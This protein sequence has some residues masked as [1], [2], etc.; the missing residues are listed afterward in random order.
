MEPGRRGGRGPPAPRVGLGYGG[1][2]GSRSPARSRALAGKAPLVRGLDT[3]SISGP[4]GSGTGPRGDRES[5]RARSRWSP[6]TKLSPSAVQGLG[7]LVVISVAA[8][9]NNGQASGLFWLRSEGS[10]PNVAFLVR[11]LL[12][13]GSKNLRCVQRGLDTVIS[14]PFGSPGFRF[15]FRKIVT[16]KCPEERGWAASG[17]G[18]LFALESIAFLFLLRPFSFLPVDFLD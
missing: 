17:G 18:R 16:L 5:P 9:C 6:R 14:S 13:L 15:Y 11:L 2:R 4:A 12:G 3:Y 1:A 8:T 10:Q 7:S